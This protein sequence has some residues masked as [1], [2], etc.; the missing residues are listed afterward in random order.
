[1]AQ[2][3]NHGLAWLAWA[4]GSGLNICEPKP[5]QTKP[6]P[7]FL[8]QAKPAQHYV[9]QQAKEPTRTQK[10]QSFQVSSGRPNVVV[11]SDAG[12]AKHVCG[13]AKLCAEGSVGAKIPCGRE[14]NRITVVIA[15]YCPHDAE[16]DQKLT[17]CAVKTDAS[18]KERSEAAHVRADVNKEPVGEE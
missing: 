11:R 9:T 16:E 17:I 15:R 8:G 5:D 13:R 6:K 2:A 7:W 14:K 10:E 18:T 4:S 12:K 3:R 1:M